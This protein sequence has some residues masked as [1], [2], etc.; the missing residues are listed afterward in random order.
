MANVQQ[1]SDP[2]SLLHRNGEDYATIN[3]LNLPSGVRAK[4]GG[5]IEQ[6]NEGFQQLTV[7]SVI[8]IAAVYLVMVLAFGELIAPLAILFSLPLA[9]IGGIIGLYVSNMAPDFD[10][11]HCD[12]LRFIAFGVR[13]L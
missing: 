10:D 9:I 12:R 1:L 3:A 13:L 7:A 5:S 6:M 8:A 11:S 2:V 4:I